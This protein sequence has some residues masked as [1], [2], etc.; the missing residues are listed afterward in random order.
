MQALRDDSWARSLGAIAVMLLLVAAMLS[1]CLVWRV[2]AEEASRSLPFTIAK[3]EE[4][5]IAPAMPVGEGAPA[6]QSRT[7]LKLEPLQQHPT[8][9]MAISP[10]LST[11]IV[12]MTTTVDV[13]ISN[14]VDLFSY[15]VELHFDPAIVSVEEIA[16]GG[17]PQPDFI[18]IR[19]VDNVSGTI[20]VVAT[21]SDPTPPANGSGVL[22]HI[23]FRALQGGWSPVT[24]APTELSP[25]LTDREG[26]DFPL[27]VIDGE[28][29]VIDW[30]T[31]VGQVAFQ[32]REPGPPWSCPLSV[33]LFA[34]GHTTPTYAVET[35]CDQ[36]GV[37]TVTNI[38]TG[39]YDIKVRDLHSLKNVRQDYVI[40]LGINSVNMGT[41]I[42]GDAD[43]NDV[44]D[45]L[46]FS[47]LASA[48]STSEGDPAFDPR[49][50][51]NNSGNIDI[52]DFSLLAA[53]YSLSGENVLP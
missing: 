2:E 50:D 53:N 25:S 3:G 16:E 29:V 23:T 17:F 52:L 19:S 21:Q 42:E 39:T 11:V 10:T 14:A 12:G 20:R 1:L 4:P 26:I 48:Y 32:A 49:T 28:I 30:G 9:T 31:L 35:I 45:I 22:L 47:L 24:F 15:D 46:D 36:N 44:I 38:L 7:L 41:L 13:H 27:N 43:A 18:V 40:G 5:A 37:F 34:A 6:A 33:T 51:F 8:I